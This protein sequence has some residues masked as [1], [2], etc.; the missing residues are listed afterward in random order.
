[1]SDEPG[2]DVDRGT[3]GS[4]GMRPTLPARDYYAPEIFELDKERIFQR[5]W[6]CV[7]REEQIPSPGDFLVREVAG[8]SL[9]VVRDE[10]RT[11][12]AFFNVC[13]H[14]GT[15][16]CDGEGSAGKALVCPYHAWTYALDGR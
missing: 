1:M 3:E 8:E 15:R 2:E 16:L 9:L 12:R 13:R 5:N 14:R 11:L 10:T 4:A 7:V 6:F